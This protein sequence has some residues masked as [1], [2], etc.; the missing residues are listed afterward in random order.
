MRQNRKRL[1]IGYRE[2]EGLTDYR[3]NREKLDEESVPNLK[4]RR[5]EYLHAV[6]VLIEETVENNGGKNS[7]FAKIDRIYDRLHL[8]AM[9]NRQSLSQEHRELLWIVRVRSSVIT[10]RKSRVKRHGDLDTLESLINRGLIASTKNVHDYSLRELWRALMLLISKFNRLR[11]SDDIKYYVECLLECCGKFFFITAHNSNGV[12]NHPL[13]IE[14][15]EGDQLYCINDAFITESERVFYGLQRRIFVHSSF[16]RI[17]RPPLDAECSINAVYKWMRKCID[18]PF[19]EYV[20]KDLRAELYEWHLYVGERE[21]YIHE[22]PFGDPKAYNIVAK[23]RPDHTDQ[24]I[25]QLNE[26]G[27]VRKVL[28]RMLEPPG[29]NAI[30][31]IDLEGLCI[32]IANYLFDSIFVSGK[33]LRQRSI[34]TCDQLTPPAMPVHPDRS[35][36]PWIVQSFNEYGVYY[37]GT[38][39]LFDNFARCFAEWV[40]IACEDEQIKGV[41]PGEPQFVNLLFLYKKIFPKKQQSLSDIMKKLK[42]YDNANNNFGIELPSHYRK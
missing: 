36:F 29:D 14:K 12:L 7:N 15:N 32:I 6:N 42:V 26:T 24:C 27:S 23:W 40:K 38:L 22:E 39:R 11:Y 18:G 17:V 37:D 10:H 34:V 1:K 13:F 5:S 30:V 4:H 31:D 28:D 35:R 16:T 19:L 20:E 3:L 9:T 2:P 21:R 8:Y 25:D 41:F 33:R